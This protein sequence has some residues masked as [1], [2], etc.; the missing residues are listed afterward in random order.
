MYWARPTTRA[1]PNFDA[2]WPLISQKVG[3][4]RSLSVNIQ[5]HE[6]HFKSLTNFVKVFSIKTDFR[7]FKKSPVI[8][9]PLIIFEF[10]L[11]HLIERP[12]YFDTRHEFFFRSK[13]HSFVR[14]D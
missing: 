10:G 9:Q 12:K 7:E 13:F 3:K 4:T 14:I 1:Q 11:L 2:L 5:L 6:F 8:L